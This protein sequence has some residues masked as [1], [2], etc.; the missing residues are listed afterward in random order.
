MTPP[1]PKLQPLLIESLERID[2]YENII[3]IDY[4]DYDYEDDELDKFLENLPQKSEY[5]YPLYRLNELY[6][7]MYYINE[8]YNRFYKEEPPKEPVFKDPILDIK[9]CLNSAKRGNSFTAGFEALKA[10]KYLYS[11]NIEK[12]GMSVFSIIKKLGITFKNFH[13]LKGFW[14]IYK[15]Y[16]FLPMLTEDSIEDLI[17]IKP[18]LEQ[19]WT[20]IESSTDSD[21]HGIRIKQH[22]KREFWYCPYDKLTPE[23]ELLKRKYKLV[24]DF[25]T[26]F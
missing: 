10:G 14:D 6:D 2:I 13:H 23:I 8:K 17:N 9:M 12:D 3:G 15:D 19:L 18:R 5:Y 21:I 26:T 1:T 25:E 4:K 24:K 11:L 20:H 16:A 7:T 22:W